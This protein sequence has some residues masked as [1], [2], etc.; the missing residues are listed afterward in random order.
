MGMHRTCSRTCLLAPF[1]LA[2][3]AT[4]SLAQSVPSTPGQVISPTRP[5]ATGNGLGFRSLHEGVEDVGPLGSSFQLQPIDLLSDQGFSRIY[6]VDDGSGRFQ[7]RNN[8]ITAVFSRSDYFQF[9]PPGQSPFVGPSIPPG[10]VWYIGDPIV[11]ERAQV[12]TVSPT[13]RPTSNWA[14]LAKPAGQ[15]RLVNDLY[16]PVTGRLRLSADTT[17]ANDV[18]PK[19]LDP[20]Y[21]GRIEPK[22]PIRKDVVTNEA[23]RKRRIHEMTKR[24]VL[25]IIEDDRDSIQK[26]LED[27]IELD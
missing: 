3:L 22:K 27:A 1:A 16:A 8:A 18:T 4:P 20:D 25:E 14:Q 19:D 21:P 23:Y 7:R 26:R 24:L 11:T 6:H 13:G 17:A 10:T 15:G 9:T 5:G 2:L 12:P